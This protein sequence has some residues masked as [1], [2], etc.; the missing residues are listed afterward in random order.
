MSTTT[1]QRH[2]CRCCELVRESGISIASA[3]LRASLTR[4]LL[5]APLSPDRLATRDRLLCA[6]GANLAPGLALFRSPLRCLKW[7]ASCRTNRRT[8][9]NKPYSRF[10]RG[11]VNTFTSSWYRDSPALSLLTRVLQSKPCANRRGSRKARRVIVGKQR[12]VAVDSMAARPA[13]CQ[14]LVGR[15]AQ[16]KVK[17]CFKPLIANGPGPVAADRQ[18]CRFTTS[19]RVETTPHAPGHVCWC[20]CDNTCPGCQSA[21]RDRAARLR[22]RERKANAHRIPKRSPRCARLPPAFCDRVNGMGG[23]TRSP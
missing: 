18:P 2:R 16:D 22:N 17:P 10:R 4:V 11:A 12:F 23:A 13:I 1:R 5:A 21:T 7:C 3:A 15:Y 19:V 9:Q 14:V 20:D 8:F 6:A